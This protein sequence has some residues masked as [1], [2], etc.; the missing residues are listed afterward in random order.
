MRRSNKGKGGDVYTGAKFALYEDPEGEFRL[1]LIASK[2]QMN[3]NSGKG[4]K[5]KDSAKSGIQ[6]VKKNAAT[7][8]IEGKS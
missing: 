2:G 6:S 8:A 5:S 3:A 4:Y 1:R 7:A